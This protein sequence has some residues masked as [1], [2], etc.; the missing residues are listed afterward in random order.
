MQLKTLNARFI[1]AESGERE[2]LIIVLHGRG[3]SFEGFLW[4]PNILNLPDVNYLMINAPDDYYGGYSWYDL[5]PNGGPGIMR[6][7]SLLDKVMDEVI[8]EGYRPTQ[9]ILFGFSQG[10]LMSLEWGGRT[11]HEFAAMMG[12]SGYVFDEKQLMAEASPEG[13]KVRRFLSHGTM[14]DVLP[15]NHSAQQYAALQEAGFNITF[16]TYP[17]SHTIDEAEELADIRHFLLEAFNT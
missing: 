9:T 11:S 3:D 5:P 10:C 17:K 15:Y 12:I 14:D 2:K 8:A 6:S 1:G 7:R 16:K 13:K 4:M